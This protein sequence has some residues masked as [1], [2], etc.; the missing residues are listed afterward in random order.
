MVWASSPFGDWVPGINNPKREAQ[1]EMESPF[2]NLRNHVLWLLLHS[3]CQS[4]HK[5]CLISRQGERDSISWWGGGRILKEQ[6]GPEIV[7]CFIFGKWNH[8][9]YYKVFEVI[10]ALHWLKWYSFDT[11]LGKDLG[12]PQITHFKWSVRC[13]HKAGSV[14]SA[15]C[16]SAVKELD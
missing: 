14:G 8:H 15:H 13:C 9:S 3:V 12:F 7:L 11:V 1:V 16:G 6:V 2:V 4:H 5:S 10:W